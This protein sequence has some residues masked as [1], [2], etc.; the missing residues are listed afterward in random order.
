MYTVHYYY[1]LVGQVDI[2]AENADEAR[3]KLQEMVKDGDIDYSLDEWNTP[4]E[5]RRIVDKETGETVFE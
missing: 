5:V 4:L 3:D 1:E 2:D